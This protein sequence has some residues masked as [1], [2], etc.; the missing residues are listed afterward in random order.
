MGRKPDLT[1]TKFFRA[2][3]RSANH[4]FVQELKTSQYFPFEYY[5]NQTSDHL[6]LKVDQTY[7]TPE[8]LIAMMLQ[9]VV[10]MTQAFG[11]HQIKD[12]VITVPSYFT[13]HEKEALYTAAEIADLKVLNLIEENTAAALH[14]GMD[15]TFDTP[16]TVLYYNM[17]ASSV[18]VT[19]VTYSSYSGPGNKKVSQFEII[20]K[21]WDD[22]LG[23]FNFD[24]K[25]TE[26][27]AS[28]FNEAWNKKPSGKGKD[29]RDFLRPMTRLRLEANKVKEVL[30][31][32]NEYPIRAEQLHADVDLVTKV[33]RADFE[34]AC[35]DLIDRLT[36]P[37]QRALAKANISVADIHSVELLGGAVRMPKVKKVLDN[38][39]QESKIVVGQ[40]LNG[41]E[42]MALGAAF[43]AANLSTA[44]RVRKV[45]MSEIASYGV[46]ISLADLD[47]ESIVEGEEPLNKHAVLYPVKTTIPSKSKTVAFNYQK[48]ILC[49][50]EYQSE[51]LPA[52]ISP[53]LAVYNITGISAFAKEYPNGS[54]KVHLTFGLD[55]S[56]ISS[57]IKAEITAE[58]PNFNETTAAPEVN[59][60]AS[61]S[62]NATEPVADAPIKIRKNSVIRRVLTVT[63]DLSKITPPRW[64]SAQIEEAKSRLRAL[65]RADDLRK[66]KAAALNDLEAYI[67]KV[68]NRI[69]DE[70]DKLKAVST[71]EQRQEVIDLANAAEDWLYDEG[72]NQEV[73]VYRTKQKDISVKADAIFSRYEEVSN[74]K[75]AIEGAHK[76]LASIRENMSNWSETLPQINQEEI[77]QMNKYMTAIENWIEEKES[78][79]LELSPFEQPVYHSKEIPLQFKALNN[80]YEKLLKKPKPA[81]PA[82]VVDKVNH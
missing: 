8:E 12:C 70:E 54:P 51:G 13:Q 61:D 45:G 19:V 18:Q 43:R 58:I 5:A 63:H 65:N 29:V 76:L 59:A 77:D 33:T 68:K 42:A 35:A 64:T 16:Q 30:S 22:N 73:E 81:P 80:L 28:R 41:D 1:F 6:T 47:V 15:R 23:G 21:D 82:P 31:A 66:A 53:L 11:G 50:I 2:L 52:D 78:K 74:R 14:Y 49:K 44:F 72:R 17:G 60:T 9:H 46:A 69:M 38:F 56:G 25:L 34:E 26:L 39:F 62:A 67:Y 75:Q 79:Q 36:V 32:N 37:I 24:L 10:D 57:L 55:Q 3:G 40:H 27:L 20:G 71:E 4:R 48:D 7:Y